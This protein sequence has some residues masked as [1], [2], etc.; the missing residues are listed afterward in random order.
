MCATPRGGPL[1]SDR[2]IISSTGL[3][4]LADGKQDVKVLRPFC[5][6]PPFIITPPASLVTTMGSRNNP[7]GCWEPKTSTIQ[8]SR[9]VKFILVH[10]IVCDGDNEGTWNT[11]PP[12][13]FCVLC[14]IGWTW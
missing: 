1:E 7:V 3:I 9:W 6:S 13:L 12:L 2:P 5:V 11:R 8:F 10:I 14:T 4:V